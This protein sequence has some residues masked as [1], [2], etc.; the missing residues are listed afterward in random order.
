MN[1]LTN[2]I[3]WQQQWS[4]TCMNGTMAT[5]GGLVFVGRSDGRFT[6]L[7]SATGHRLWAF[8]TDAGVAASSSTFE[9]GG[10]QYVVLLSG[11]NTINGGRRGDSLWLLSLDGTIDALPLETGAGAPGAGP[12]DDGGAAPVQPPVA[13]PTGA[14]DLA[15][16]ARLYRQLCL[17]CHGEN[18]SGG[19]G[20]GAPLTVLGRDFQAVANVAWHGRN[21]MP[22]FRGTLTVEQVRDIARYIA[23]ELMAT[24]HSD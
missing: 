12:G 21:T 5:G 17:A 8:Q 24:G 3:A 22:A 13:L 11:G 4:T 19:Q 23:E 18:G 14:A 2:R 20:N 6:A 10:K 7:D 16:G 1:L 15:Q 9:H